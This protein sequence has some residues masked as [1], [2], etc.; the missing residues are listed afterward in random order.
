MKSKSATYQR[1]ALRVAACAMLFAIILPAASVRGMDAENRETLLREA[2]EAY[3]LGLGLQ[4]ENPAQRIAHF[5][6][7]A[8]GFEAVLSSGIDNGYLQYNLANAYLQLDELGKAILHYRRAARL[9][10]ADESLQANL[11]FARSL[12]RNQIQSSGEK[13]LFETVFFWHYE[14]SAKARLMVGLLAY[15]AFWMLMSLR[16]LRKRSSFGTVSALLAVVWLSAGVSVGAEV[17]NAQNTRE[18]V[19]VQNDITVRKGNGEA[20]APAFEELLH[21]GVEFVILEERPGWYRIELP[22]GNAGWIRQSQGE[23]V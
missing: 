1:T 6:K 15:V 18:G 4:D 19:T 13:E 21:E 8:T 17:Y 3:D 16:V 12:R 14:T 2:I 22:D 9:I 5:R 7:A 11:K 23:V 10:G 20:A